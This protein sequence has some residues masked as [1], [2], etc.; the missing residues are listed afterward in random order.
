MASSSRRTRKAKPS[1]QLAPSAKDSKAR[2][3]S[4]LEKLEDRNF[5]SASPFIGG[6]LVVYRVGDGSIALTNGGNPIFMDEYSPTGQLVQSIEMPFSSNPND[7]EGGVHSPTANPNPILN[8]GSATPSGVLLLSADGKSLSF[9]GYDVSMPSGLN[10]TNLKARTDIARD[11]GFVD[12][13]GNVDTSTAPPDYTINGSSGN[14]P[15]GAISFTDPSLITASN[16]NGVGFYLFSQQI[17]TVN[18]APLGTTGSSTPL[19]NSGDT[20]TG[21]DSLQIYNGQ[22]YGMSSAGQIYLITNNSNP[23]VLPKD[24]HTTFTQLAGISVPNST[25]PVDFFFTTL[26]PAD[27]GT[28]PDT[29]Y[30]TSPSSAVADAYT[31]TVNGQSLTAHGKILKYTAN[32]DPITHALTGGWHASGFVE[33]DPTANDKGQVTGLTGYST[34]SSVVMYATSGAANANA[35]QYGGSLFTFTDTSG[36]DGTIPT[37]NPT[38]ANSATTLVPFF[39][40]FNQGFRGVAFAPNLAPTLAAATYNFPSIAENP[41]TNQGQLV[42]SIL[43]GAGARQ[44]PPV[45]IKASPLPASIKPTKASGSTALTMAR[46]G[47][48]SPPSQQ[49]PR[50]RSLPI[51]K[52]DSGSSPIKTTTAAPRSLSSLGINQKAPTAALSISLT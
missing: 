13:N 18:F 40:A 1:K 43:A 17:G 34:G 15:A 39:N 36:F 48:R 31:V 52:A 30:V 51:R 23:N 24:V 44:T 14:T 26:D 35:G 46:V 6:D 37:G 28:Q 27:H 47:T 10:N 2:F 11:A 22:L 3:T 49:M 42:S 5:L 38:S 20:T 25:K 32:Y 12:I 8:A 29:L 7:V 41:T 9:T 50:S 16:P 21:M 4:N 19:G 33:V 45:R